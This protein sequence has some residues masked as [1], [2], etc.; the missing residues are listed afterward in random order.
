MLLC[1]LS[2]GASVQAEAA[3]LTGTITW[4]N[5]Q[6]PTPAFLHND[7]HVC[8]SEGPVFERWVA[9]DG[10]GGVRGVVVYLEGEGLDTR[11]AKRALRK[12]SKRRELDQRNCMFLP[13]VV[14]A[15]LGAVLTIR[16]SDPLLHNA[17]LKDER[18]K[19][20]FNLTL[21]VGQQRAKVRLRWPGKLSFDCD[22][23]HSWMNASVLV[24]AHPFF[25]KSGAQ[26]RYRI[27]NIPK[28]KFRLVAWHPD[29]GAKSAPVEIKSD[30][31]TLSIRFD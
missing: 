16:N 11:G 6:A 13:R 5:P 31:Q 9:V 26:G 8:G 29:L 28:G 22:A 21:P 14:T 2:L 24:F 17:H 12:M 25:T 20:L 30:E 4:S 18:G 10:R 23:G 3:T 1:G 7:R 27:Q 19:T 15:P